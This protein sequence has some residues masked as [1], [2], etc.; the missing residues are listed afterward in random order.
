MKHSPWE[1]IK[2]TLNQEGLVLVT[3]G[4]M[5]AVVLSA[6]IWLVIAGMLPVQDYGRANYVL[7]YGVLIASFATLGL[8]ITVQTYLPKGEDRLL[9]S[10]IILIS[11]TSLIASLPFL[12][13]H[14]SIPF[15]VLSNSLFALA[16]KERLGRM[17]YRDYALLQGAS[18]VALLVLIFILVPAWG[19][20]GIL[21]GFPAVYLAMSSWLLLNLRGSLGSF[22]ALKRYLKF[23]F[24][25]LLTG[26]VGT[27]GMRLDKVLIGYLY[28][29]ETLG[30]YQLA[31]Q[32]YSAMLVI[33][34]SLSN[35]LLSEKSSG[36]RTKLAEVMGI[37][38][39]VMAAFAGFLLIPL[40][41]EKLFPRFYPVS[42]VAAQIVAFAIV[43][44]SI[45]SIWSAGK[46]S[47]E[48][49]KVIL[50]VNTISVSI[51]V[52]LLYVLGSRMG[53][54]GLAVSLLIYRALASIMGVIESK[55]GVSGPESQQ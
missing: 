4:N 10:S 51:F 28:G 15:I 45:F 12:S 11:V 33:P 48:N 17:R 53:V 34:A 55:I 35:Y 52:V 18:R 39:S 27:M 32:F 14:P 29:N 54:V 37:M 2:A 5:A 8:P 43:F 50:L 47:E 40:V 7:S 31:F 3:V 38:L 16:I 9:P 21:Y 24:V 41:V 36:R 6:I 20:E 49:P 23:A 25:A 26:I 30:Y 22:K 13:I 19:V 44:D 42:A 46:Y 1:L